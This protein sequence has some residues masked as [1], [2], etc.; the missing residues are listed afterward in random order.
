M[1]EC[2][3]QLE[4]ALGR[5]VHLAPLDRAVVSGGSADGAV[6][7]GHMVGARVAQ[8]VGGHVDGR[9]EALRD[10]DAVV[11]KGCA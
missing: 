8:L 7:K 10:G 6:H 11:E 1:F 3:A 5:R 2:R 9:E 4:E